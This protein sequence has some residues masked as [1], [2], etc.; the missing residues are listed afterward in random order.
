MSEDEMGSVADP[1][2]RADVRIVEELSAG[3]A[4]TRTA[5]G[6]L[7]PR[8]VVE[9]W[10]IR[11]AMLSDGRRQILGFVLPGDSVGLF[12][13]ERALNRAEARALT[14]LRLVEPPPIDGAGATAAN[15]FLEI[16]FQ[17]ECLLVNHVLNLGRR[18][19][20]ER[21]AHLFLELHDR[22]GAVGLSNDGVFDFPPT[23]EVL[24]DA[25]GLSA[26]HSSD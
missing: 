22:L 15:P 9:G 24:A 1:R 2:L 23:Q 13:P 4:L 20:Y 25:L 3:E 11:Y 17:E 18:T 19:A 5:A 14:Y 16:A 21:T 6:A 12:A 8:T 26:V 10:A 7:A